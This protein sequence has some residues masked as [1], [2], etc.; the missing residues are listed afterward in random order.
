MP[1]LPERFWI[2][3]KDKELIVDFTIN[4]DEQQII[5]S[6]E[7]DNLDE[8]IFYLEKAI[9]TRKAYY[10]EELRVFNV[11]WGKYCCYFFH[12]DNVIIIYRAILKMK[13]KKILKT[14]E[15]IE[16]MFKE[17]ITIDAIKEWNGDYSLFDDF[18]TRLKVYFKMSFF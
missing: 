2:F 6:F 17:L 14:C 7:V 1:T 8:I 16:S 15:I 4:K 12:D 3:T 18:I 9:D 10:K 5:T 11:G 13:D